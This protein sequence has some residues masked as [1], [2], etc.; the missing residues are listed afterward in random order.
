[1]S[2]GRV[3]QAWSTLYDSIHLYEELETALVS[4]IVENSNFVLPRQLSRETRALQ[5]ASLSDVTDYFRDRRDYIES[6][7]TLDLVVS[8]ERALREDHSERLNGSKL[9]TSTIGSLVVSTPNAPGQS[10]PAA[11]RLLPHWKSANGANSAL[12][13]S[14]DEAM[15]YRNWL[16]HG[17]IGPPPFE[18][19]PFVLHTPVEHLLNLI[20]QEP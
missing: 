19:N 12:L 15:Q 5:L 20:S 6:V 7:A 11:R 1:M 4:A 3:S 18:P 2:L 14:I 16:T 10:H 13:D 8:V 17:R 9:A